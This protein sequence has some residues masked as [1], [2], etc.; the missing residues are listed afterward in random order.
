MKLACEIVKDLL[1]LY[2]DDLCSRESCTAIENH[3]EECTECRNLVEGAKKLSGLTVPEPVEKEVS[4]GGE[5]SGAAARQAAVI[6][7][8]LRKIKRRWLQS[9]ISAI[10]VLPFCIL[11]GI[12]ISNQVRKQGIC[13]TNLDEIFT[14]Y[15]FANAMEQENYE[16]AVEFLDYEELY[17]EIQELV[18]WFPAEEEFFFTGEEYEYFKAEYEKAAAM[19]LEEFTEIMK[20]RSLEDMFKC[21]EQGITFENNGYVFSYFISEN[22]N[23]IIDYGFLVNKDGEKCRMEIGFGVNDGKLSMGASSGGTEE[24]WFDTVHD[25]FDLYYMHW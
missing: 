12:M 16:K 1:L 7:G 2:E 13:F 11:L 4:E 17:R 23:W 22:G 15:R 14:V 24:D 8:S 18:V 21:R 20:V 19:S 3:L 25:A 5:M 9:L 10:I 6:A